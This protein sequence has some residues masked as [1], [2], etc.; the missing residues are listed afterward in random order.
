MRLRSA[1]QAEGNAMCKAIPWGHD[2]EKIRAWAEGRT[3]SLLAEGWKHLL[4]T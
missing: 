2:E 3:G 1:V 4:C